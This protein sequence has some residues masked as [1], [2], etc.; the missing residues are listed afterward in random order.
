MSSLPIPANSYLNLLIPKFAEYRERP[1]L[2]TPSTDG[3]ETTWTSITYGQFD[4]YLERIAVYWYECLHAQ[5][6]KEKDVVGLW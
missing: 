5:G 2:W 4:F 1:F 6:L 3:G